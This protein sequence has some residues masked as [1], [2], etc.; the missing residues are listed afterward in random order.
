MGAQASRLLLNGRRDA[1]VPVSKNETKNQPNAKLMKTKTTLLLSLACAA[2]PRAEA[3]PA[4]SAPVSTSARPNIIVILADDLGYGDLSCMYARDMRTPNL[5]KF[6]SEGVRMDNFYANSSLCSPSRASLL[7]GRYC[8]M[9][10][11]QGVI[12][13]ESPGDYMNNFGYFKPG[14]TVMPQVLKANGYA[15]ALIGKWHLGYTS[16]NIPNERG[17]DLFKGILGGM[18]D[19]YYTHIRKGFPALRINNDVCPKVE[20]H[21]TDILTNWA[22]DYTREQHAKGKPY[23][24]Y[25][26]YNAPHVPLHAPEDWVEKVKKRQP[27]ITDTR[28]HLVA[29]IEHMDAG[30]GR[31]F[32]HLKKSGQWDNTFIVFTS[33]NGGFRGSEANNGPY[34]GYKSSMYEGGLRLPTAFF[35]KGRIEK[36]RSASIAQMMDIFPTICDLLGINPGA[37]T[38]F[39]G[40]SILPALEGK[41]QVTDDRYFWYLVREMGP[42]GNKLQTAVRKGPYKLLQNMASEPYEFY[43]L[44]KDPA[45]EH[46]LKAGPKDKT[47]KDLFEQMRKR[48]A[49]AG[50]VPWNI[51]ADK[52]VDWTD[53][54]EK[55]GLVRQGPVDTKKE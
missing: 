12:R 32:D 11:V 29:L 55:L 5:D 15:T 36:R 20:G 3:A 53:M 17:F 35:L 48:I 23:F 41:K 38:T 8:D 31:L 25:L 37:D 33:D 46:P 34:R 44:S 22:I 52:Y 19:D 10:G 18:M 49:C 40:I 54:N 7:T 9:A 16:P 4:N 47:Y 21:I 39:D 51:P 1:C 26:A 27:G 14:I 13:N 2:L 6:F 28:A 24:L 30:I 42:T 45:E 50:A 43:D